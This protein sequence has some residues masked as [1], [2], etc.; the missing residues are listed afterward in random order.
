MSYHEIHLVNNFFTYSQSN[1]TPYK[2]QLFSEALRL[3]PDS[4]KTAFRLGDT[5]AKKGDF[6]QATEYFRQAV[7][8]NPLDMKNH[9]KLALALVFQERYDEAVEQLRTGI[10]IMSGNGRKDDA[11]ELQKYL[12]LIED[13][14]ANKK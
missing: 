5:L 2:S 11:A 6:R 10:R 14:S 1:P 8:M 12:K 3:K 4:A 9:S 13:K 7:E